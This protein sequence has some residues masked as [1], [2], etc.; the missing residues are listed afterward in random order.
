[1]RHNYVTGVCYMYIL[2]FFL[3]VALAISIGLC[4]YYFGNQK[5][6]EKDA[7]NLNELLSE[8]S[9]SP[10]KGIS[11]KV[12]NEICEQI[13][14]SNDEVVCFFDSQAKLRFWNQ[15]SKTFWNLREGDNFEHFGQSLAPES[16]NKFKKLLKDFQNITRQTVP[17]VVEMTWKKGKSKYLYEHRF[18]KS[19]KNGHIEGIAMA[20]KLLREM[21]LAETSSDKIL[22]SFPDK[23]AE[24]ID[25]IVKSNKDLASLM[26]E[27]KVDRLQ[28]TELIKNQSSKLDQVTGLLDIFQLSKKLNSAEEEEAVSRRAISFFHQIPFLINAMSFPIKIEPNRSVNLGFSKVIIPPKQFLDLVAS[29]FSL[30]IELQTSEKTELSVK[31]NARTDDIEVSYIFLISSTILGQEVSNVWY[32]RLTDKNIRYASLVSRVEKMGVRIDHQE[33][34]RSTTELILACPK[35]IS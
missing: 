27:E 20:A 34:N 12:W 28:L 32:Q 7:K 30:I 25:E 17:P 19:E 9:K 18:V 22:D 26:E 5:K 1:M 35:D 16:V 8:T 21:P 29:L 2:I 15:K 14:D 13:L 24:P 31:F 4:V 3:I 11:Q 33:L 10:V 6:L 23:V